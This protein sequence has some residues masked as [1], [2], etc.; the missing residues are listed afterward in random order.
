MIKTFKELQQVLKYEKKLYPNKLY[1]YLTSNQRVY[2]WR[3]VRA[4]RWTEYFH[5]ASSCIL[6]KFLYILMARKKTRLG[7]KIGVEIDINTFNKGLL[8][9]HSGNI[10]VGSGAS[11]GENCQL[12]GDNCIG[13]KGKSGENPVPIIGNNVDVGVGAKIIGDVTIADNV[14]IGANAVVT[15]SFLKPGCTIAGV[16]AIVIRL[17]EMK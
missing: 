14:R 2:N 15:H 8:I 11:I 13:N 17:E 9:H 16:P 5:N 12:H 10:V 4:L 6:F 3:F 1:D 7:V